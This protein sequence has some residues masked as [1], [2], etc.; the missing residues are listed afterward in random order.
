[1]DECMEENAIQLNCESCGVSTVIHVQACFSGEITWVCG[2]C[3]DSLVL[4][5]L[6]KK[7]ENI[8][9]AIAPSVNN[10]L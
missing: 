9:L 8:H 1:M 2:P 10:R 3:Q 4:E 6:W 7:Q 5:D